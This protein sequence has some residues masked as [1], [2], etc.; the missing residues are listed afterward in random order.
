MSNSDLHSIQDALEQLSIRLG[1][2]MDELT[3]RFEDL[4]EPDD[5]QSLLAILVD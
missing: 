3:E 2:T 4:M 1:T 5:Y